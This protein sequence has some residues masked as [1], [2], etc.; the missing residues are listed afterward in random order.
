ME[1][2][3]LIRLGMNRRATLRK[4]WVAVMT[5]ALLTVAGCGAEQVAVKEGK[6]HTALGPLTEMARQGTEQRGVIYVPAH[7]SVYWGFDRVESELAIA[8]YI[9]NVNQKQ[10]IVVHSARYFDSKGKLVRNYVEQPGALGPMAT[11]DYVIQRM[12]TSGGT[13]ASFLVEWSGPADGEAP[14]VEAVMM[15]QHGNLGI[16]FSSV[17]RALGNR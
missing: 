10:G 15:G 3:K 13:G 5:L 17:G 14:M 1:G 4:F 7:S 8:L 9:R 2:T 11:A 6:G 12:D 16:S